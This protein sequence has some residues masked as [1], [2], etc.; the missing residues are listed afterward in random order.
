MKIIA[1]ATVAAAF[2]VGAG[3][4][5]PAVVQAEQD[6][7]RN[8]NEELVQER[9]QIRNMSEGERAR[10]EKEMQKRAQSMSEGERKRLGIDDRGRPVTGDP[11]PQRTRTNEDNEH[12]Q[13]ELQR[14]RQRVEGGDSYGSGYEARH[15]INRS[16]NAGG[17]GG[18]GAG[19]GGRGR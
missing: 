16:G 11:S 5:V 3:I 9:A 10:F 4:I 1:L 13:G 7:S 2:A 17:M 19:S 14:E 12:G 8:T 15:G 18:R 6:F